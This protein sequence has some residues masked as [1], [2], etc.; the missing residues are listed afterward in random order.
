M[1]V[2][3]SEVYDIIAQF[4]DAYLKTLKESLVLTLKGLQAFE[5]EKYFASIPLDDEPTTDMDR[6]IFAERKDEVSYSFDEV[7]KELGLW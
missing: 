3:R 2:E 5:Q 6:A 7:K 1:S 4:P